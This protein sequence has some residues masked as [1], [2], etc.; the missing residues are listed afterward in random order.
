MVTVSGHGQAHVFPIT[1]SPLRA[2]LHRLLPLGIL[3]PGNGDKSV[4]GV[5][6]QAGTAEVTELKFSGRKQSETDVSG[7][8]CPQQRQTITFTSQP[9]QR[10]S[11]ASGR[12][13]VGAWSEA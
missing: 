13:S 1:R 12:G 3:Q 9:H 4:G 6:G 7:A 10:G 11:G 8:L 5:K 2:A